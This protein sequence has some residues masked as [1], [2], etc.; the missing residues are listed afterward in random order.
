[1]QAP[2]RA[3]PD[4]PC[5][6]AP[7]E[8]L[9]LG[10][11]LGRHRDRRALLRRWPPEVA[12]ALVEGARSP[13]AAASRWS[14]TCSTGSRASARAFRSG[15][16]RLLR[17]AAHRGVEHTSMVGMPGDTA[18]QRAR[19]IAGSR[20]RIAPCG[21]SS[22]RTCAW[23]VVRRIAGLRGRRG[24]DAGAARRRAASPW[25][26]ARGAGSVAGRLGF[27]QRMHRLTATHTGSM[28]GSWR[29]G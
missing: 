5:R 13:T 7:P 23:S 4:R 14:W 1:M 8:Q 15:G 28:L 27:I 6:L 3:E 12:E 29:A 11:E 2:R 17:R 21:Q 26:V 22:R 19:S 20:R 24:G 18:G 9:E 25:Q 10:E 16:E